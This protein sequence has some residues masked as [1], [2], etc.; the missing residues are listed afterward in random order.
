MADGDLARLFHRLTSYEPGRE[1][2]DAIDDPWLVTSFEPNDMERI[3]PPVKELP[4]ELPVVSLPRTLPTAGPSALEALGGRVPT[5]AQTLDLPHLA[6]LLYLSAGV[7]RTTVGKSGYTHLF[8]AAGSA[9]GRF[10]LEV[11][12]V[13]PD[14]T[15]GLPA[16]VHSYRP[17]EHALT[18]VAPPPTGAVPAL[19]VTGVPWRTGWRYRERGYRHVFWDAG[20][21]LSQVSRSPR[22][23]GSPPGSSRRSPISS[24]AT[25]SVRTGLPSSPSRSSRSG[26][27]TPA[28]SR[29]R[30]VRVA[31]SIP[32]PSTSRS[33]T[34]RTGRGSACGGASRGIPGR[35]SRERCRRRGRSTRR[36]TDAARP[37]S[38][39]PRVA[40]R[41]R[42]STRRSASRSAA[43]TSRTSSSCT[44]P[45]L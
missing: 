9:G 37:G 18:Q 28:G 26:R 14:G 22:A 4:P 6:R 29:L 25:S 5:I 1:W 32:R 15:E 27:E 11:Y 20:T 39:I 17:V 19:V 24:S 10:P 16:G 45:A 3:P 21:M 43:S 8:R 38:W 36:S 30:E 42:R 34:R 23:R 41:G 33:S 7:V 35:R 2:D 44:T 12:V 31:R 40:S 13:V